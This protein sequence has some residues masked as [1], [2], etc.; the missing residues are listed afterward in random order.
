M[1]A[2]ASPNGAHYSLNS[3]ITLLCRAL[4]SDKAATTPSSIRL[5]AL[6]FQL[7]LAQKSCCASRFTLFHSIAG[8][9]IS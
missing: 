4:H 7:R 8:T 2:V 1:D 5:L 6:L 3:Q 9:C